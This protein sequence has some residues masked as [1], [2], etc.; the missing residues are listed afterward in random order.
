M[1]TNTAAVQP[2]VN[3]SSPLIQ[4]SGALAGVIIFILLLAWLL[5]R[6]GFS[7][8][9]GRG[10][11]TLNISSSVNLGL[12]ERIVVVDVDDAR[13]VLGV[14]AT[15]ITH[16]HTLPPSPTTE[17]PV[18]ENA[19]DFKK[20]IKNIIKNSGKK[21]MKCLASLSLFL[22]LLMVPAA[23]SAQLPGIISQP[24]ANGAQ[25]W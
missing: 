14:T 2:T 3:T 9:V 8:N 22:P 12:R 20:L 23:V 4:V 10:K 21:I 11:K 18:S 1:K 17:T 6:F 24:L 7:A 5:K 15:Q 19:G 13:L 16:L 25:S